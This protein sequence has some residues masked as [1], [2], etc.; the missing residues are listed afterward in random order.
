MNNEKRVIKIV[1]LRKSHYFEFRDL[2]LIFETLFSNGEKIF[3][4]NHLHKMGES[5][6]QSYRL[7]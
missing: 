6:W 7:L 4:S 1:I 3:Y 5:R 2:V